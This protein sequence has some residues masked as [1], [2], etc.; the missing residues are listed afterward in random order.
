VAGEEV[1][2]SL[3]VC[4]SKHLVAHDTEAGPGHST[5]VWVL[6]P[7]RIYTVHFQATWAYGLCCFPEGAVAESTESGTVLICIS[8]PSWGPWLE[9]W[10]EWGSSSIQTAYKVRSR[11][12]MQTRELHDG[13]VRVNG[14]VSGIRF[15]FLKS[16]VTVTFYDTLHIIK[17]MIGCQKQ[18]KS[19][20]FRDFCCFI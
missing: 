5:T 8:H 9:H 7:G 2:S 4:D 6:L 14:Y 15:K 13:C 1:L 11:D 19:L 20:G 12:W 3:W 16:Y 10:V 17:C 18:Y